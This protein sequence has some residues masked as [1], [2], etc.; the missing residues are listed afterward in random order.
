[1]QRIIAHDIIEQ[2]IAIVIHHK[3]IGQATQKGPHNEYSRNPTQRRPDAA[4]HDERRCMESFNAPLVIRNKIFTKNRALSLCSLVNTMTT[5]E[6]C[7]TE[8]REPSQFRMSHLGPARYNMDCGAWQGGEKAPTDERRNA[9]AA[10][11]A[12]FSPWWLFH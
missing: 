4:A 6:K 12:T 1:M 10:K 7:I 8:S 5:K 9:L 2:L 3:H 11:K